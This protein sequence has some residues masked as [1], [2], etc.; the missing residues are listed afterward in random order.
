[1][2]TRDALNGDGELATN[3]NTRKMS[4]KAAVMALMTSGPKTRACNKR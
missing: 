1:M 3:R 4:S 2:E